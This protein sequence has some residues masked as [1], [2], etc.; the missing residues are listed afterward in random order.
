[1]KNT[2]ILLSYLVMIALGAISCQCVGYKKIEQP[3]ENGRL[4]ASGWQKNSLKTGQ[5]KN[6]S[7][8]GWLESREKWTNGNLKWTIFYNEKHQKISWKNNKG[9]EK[10]FKSCGCNR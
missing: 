4:K 8:T 7:V 3:W 6:Y 1:M 9:E 10:Y 2:L 5:W